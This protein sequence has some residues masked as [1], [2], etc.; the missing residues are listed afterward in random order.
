MDLWVWCTSHRGHRVLLQMCTSCVYVNTCKDA[1]LRK[2]KAEPSLSALLLLFHPNSSCA[3]VTD[4][5]IN[6]SPKFVQKCLIFAS[7][8]PHSNPKTSWKEVS[9]FT[10]SHFGEIV[11]FLETIKR[12]HLHEKREIGRCAKKTEEFGHLG[13]E[14]LWRC[15]FWYV[16][17]RKQNLRR[18]VQ[19]ECS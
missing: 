4:P 11:I 19:G 16:Q 2:T 8:Q 12:F 9:Q 15:L 6:Q 14:F 7:K 10:K 17:F 18:Q 1:I 3:F 5:K 13:W